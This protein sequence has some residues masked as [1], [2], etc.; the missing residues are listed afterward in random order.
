MTARKMLRD[1]QIHH[2]LSSHFL[3]SL[4]REIDTEILP[5]RTYP[6]YTAE[7]SVTKTGKLAARYQEVTS[8]KECLPFMTQ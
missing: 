7:E 2:L 5:V 4:V 8:T 3:I 6:L 1:T